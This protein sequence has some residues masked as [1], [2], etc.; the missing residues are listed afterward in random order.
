[1]TSTLIPDV[2]TTSSRRYSLVWKN[3]LALSLLVFIS[4][5]C[6]E[7]RFSFASKVSTVAVKVS[8]EIITTSVRVVSRTGKLFLTMRET[9]SETPSAIFSTSSC[10]I[11]LFSI[12]SLRLSLVL[13]IRSPAS[14]C[15]ESSTLLVRASSALLMDDRV[16]SIIS[17]AS[18][19]ILS[20]S[21]ATIICSIWS[22]SSARADWSIE[23]SFV[24]IARTVVEST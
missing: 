6:A 10:C 2:S 4:S 18:A 13:A 12:N 15:T 7:V 11:W 5:I 23:R 21:P 3:S 20:I 8:P 24:S 17:C 14:D 16:V 22:A 1:M 9:T 19:R